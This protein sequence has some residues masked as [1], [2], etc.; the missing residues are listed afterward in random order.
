MS[1]Q[2]ICV[3]CG[4]DLGR[5]EWRAYDLATKASLGHLPCW[6]KPL[7]VLGVDGDVWACECV[8]GQVLTAFFHR[9]CRTRRTCAVSR[10][11]DA[12]RFKALL[13]HQLVNL[14]GAIFGDAGEQAFLRSLDEGAGP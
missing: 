9:P 2:E 11:V 14:R 5:G 4:H 12:G 3:R 1:Q 6:G 7:G 10:A 8:T 13:G